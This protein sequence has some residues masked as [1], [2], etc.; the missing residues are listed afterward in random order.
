MNMNPKNDLDIDNLVP[1]DDSD[2]E[3]YIHITM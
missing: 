3:V 1:I 2:E